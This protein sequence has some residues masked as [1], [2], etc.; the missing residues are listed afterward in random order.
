MFFWATRFDPRGGPIGARPEVGA[1]HLDD[2]LDS[3]L[4][5]ARGGIGEKTYYRIRYPKYAGASQ[6]LSQGFR[7]LF[8]DGSPKPGE[9]QWHRRACFG[10]APLSSEDF[11]LLPTDARR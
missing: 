3:P 7:L 11:E 5:A 9:V 8:L 1:D 10:R 6:E 2:A 4:G